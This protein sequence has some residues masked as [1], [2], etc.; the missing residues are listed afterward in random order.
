HFQSDR[1]VVGRTVRL[2][3]CSYTVLGV[4]PEGFRGTEFFYSP[5]LWAPLVDQ[6]QIEGS[7]NLDSRTNR[8]RWVV[9]RLK[10][11]VTP[12]QATADLKDIAAYLAKAYPNEDDGIAFA[13]TRP[14]LAG[15]M[16][17]RPVHA[18]VSG[19]MVLA[20]LILIAACAN[21]GGLFAARA[22]DRT[23]EVA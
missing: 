14:G 9:G 3:K 20:G 22:A 17:G 10:A 1:D 19:L 11:G 15:D 18:F 13:L 6:Q 8:G 5:A 4:A 16:L 2:N 12:A 21:L 23:R 7:S